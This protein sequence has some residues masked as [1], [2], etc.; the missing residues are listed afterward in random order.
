MCKNATG[1]SGVEL[2]NAGASTSGS[3]SATNSGSAAS[4]TSSGAADNTRVKA[5]TVVGALAVGIGALI[6]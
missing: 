2:E 3:G 1:V 6:L 5:G 4:S